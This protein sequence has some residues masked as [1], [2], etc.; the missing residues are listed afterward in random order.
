[1]TMYVAPK[2]VSG[3]VVNTSKQASAA[4]D[5]PSPPAQ[6]KGLIKSMSYSSDQPQTFQLE[7]ALG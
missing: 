7:L 6:H 2:M 4:I 5:V 1:M 3:R